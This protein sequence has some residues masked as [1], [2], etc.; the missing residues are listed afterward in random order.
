MQRLALPSL[1]LMKEM[2]LESRQTPRQ[3]NLELVQQIGLHYLQ[4]QVRTQEVGSQKTPS[5]AA[6]SHE[7]P[8]LFGAG[9]LQY[10]LAPKHKLC[11]T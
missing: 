9:C 2:L 1:Q 3:L 11:I 10:G 5:W 7:E 4:L 6:L 8:S